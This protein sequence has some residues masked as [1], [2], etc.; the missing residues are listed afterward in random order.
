MSNTINPDTQNIFKM[1]ACYEALTPQDAE[2]E[3]RGHRERPIYKVFRRRISVK[4][5]RRRR[6]FEV[7][8]LTFP[9]DKAG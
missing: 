7:T 5:R 6:S 8:P 3:D 9:G 4:P 1:L 2:E